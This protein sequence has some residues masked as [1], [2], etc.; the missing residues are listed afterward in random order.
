MLTCIHNYFLP[1]VSSP[2]F[3]PILAIST[4]PKSLSNVIRWF[5]LHHPPFI[6]IHSQIN[7]AFTLSIP[8]LAPSSTLV[9]KFFTSPLDPH[10][11]RLVSSLRGFFES[12][13]ISQGAIDLPGSLE[14]KCEVQGYDRFGRMG[15]VWVSKPRSSR[16]GSAGA[17]L[18]GFFF[19]YPAS[20]WINADN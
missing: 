17:F 2:C 16:S 7:Q 19:L 4:A 12:P 8:L 6:M 3:F 18:D 15:G 10:G 5:C 14:G 11:S 1:L 20:H 13:T 9:F